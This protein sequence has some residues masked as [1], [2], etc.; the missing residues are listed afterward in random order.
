MTQQAALDS[1]PWYREPMMAL[2]LGLPLLSI[3]AGFSLLGIA[4]HAGGADA[5]PQEVRRTGK[6]QVGD[7]VADAQAERL[8]LR[9]HLSVD[10]ETGAV[11]LSFLE[12]QA[13][14][15]ARLELRLIHPTA[16]ASDIE[17]PLLRHNAGYVGRM[18]ATR[19][20]D[21]LVVLSPIDPQWRLIARL[22]AQAD[23]VRLH[24]ALTDQ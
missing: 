9:A 3:V 10:R 7:I 5:I 1:R 17:I 11:T 8:G 24:P 15:D 18:E 20:H 6:A 22:A 16:A 12:G 23:D 13:V 21:W 4:I 2:V 14:H 19:R